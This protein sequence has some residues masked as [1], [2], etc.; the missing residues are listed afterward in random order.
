[1]NSKNNYFYYL[2]MKTNCSKLLV[3]PQ[4]GGTC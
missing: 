3:I 4:F 1:M 2:E